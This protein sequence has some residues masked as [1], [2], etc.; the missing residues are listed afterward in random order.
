KFCG[1]EPEPFLLVVV[2][3]EEFEGVDGVLLARFHRCSC[4]PHPQ[5]ATPRSPKGSRG[6][7]GRTHPDL[8]GQLG[9]RCI[10]PGEARLQDRRHKLLL[11]LT[12]SR[13]FV[14]L[15]IVR[16][17]HEGPSADES[18]GFIFGFCLYCSGPWFEHRDMRADVAC[19]MQWAYHQQAWPLAREYTHRRT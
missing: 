10:F 18:S 15:R 3:V 9:Y 8:F 1:S 19:Q 14:P 16:S 2:A 6:V 11:P 7:A 4:L 5:A 12:E 13:P 17:A